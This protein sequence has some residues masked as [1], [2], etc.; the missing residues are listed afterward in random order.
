MTRQTPRPVTLD[1]CQAFLIKM[2]TDSKFG[3]G[4]KPYDYNFPA[5]IHYLKSHVILTIW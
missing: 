3:D 4:C 2:W 1:T 5:K